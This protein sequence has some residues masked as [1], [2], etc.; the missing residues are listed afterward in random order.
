M[1]DRILAADAVPVRVYL[2]EPACAD[3]LLGGL[4]CTDRPLMARPSRL[5]GT[6]TSDDE[7][8]SAFPYPQICRRRVV[9]LLVGSVTEYATLSP[10]GCRPERAM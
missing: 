10:R 6:L 5:T 8:T 2:R 3:K 1:L 9:E 4:D 7:L